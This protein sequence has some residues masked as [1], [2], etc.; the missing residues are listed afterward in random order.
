M[1][2]YSA[3]RGIGL[4]GDIPIFAAPN[5]ADVWAN[6]EIFKLKADGTPAV[7]SGVPPDYFAKT[8]Q[9]WGN[10]HYRWDVLKRQGYRWWIERFQ[11]TLS[12][13][14]AARLDHF[15]G[16]VRSYEIQGD[17]PTA[18][19]GKYRSGPGESF[20]KT[21]I[22]KLGHAP[23]IAEDLGVLTPAVKRLRDHFEF[24]GM[25]VLQFAF[26]NDPEA[27]NYQPH[28]YPGN[29]VVYTGT[30]DN[31]TTAGWFREK[32]SAAS[33][34]SKADI[35]KERR[36]TLEYLHSD[37]KAIP[38]DMI[39]AAQASV[40][41]TVIIPMQDVLGL[42]SDARMNLPGTSTGNWAWRMEEKQI[43]P[44]LIKRL[45]ELAEVYG[46]V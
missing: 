39:R 6:P 38:W 19:K 7:V 40:G 14:D 32:T 1:R 23:F 37:G 13:F 26:G 25:R 5:S 42:G 30:H 20:F 43:T 31:D 11:Q 16:F 2:R 45:R 27:R 46:R 17:A 12:Y 34:R 33:A 3:G 35:E 24:P 10:P 36:F 18:E 9:R 44:S 29:C 22:R 21:V 15:I 41:H 28:N 4:I 8:G